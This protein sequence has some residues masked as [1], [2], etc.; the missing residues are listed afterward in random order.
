MTKTGKLNEL[1]ESWNKV[2]FDVFCKDG[3]ID[4]ETY[5]K[6]KI[7]ILFV[8]KDVNNAKP[9]EKVDLR[10]SL[11]TRTDEGKT[12]FNIARWYAGLNG[13]E[14]SEEITNMTSEKQHAAMRKVAVMNIKKEAGGPEV[15]DECILTYAKN[16]VEQI[17]REIEICNP[18]IV[19]ACGRVVFKSLK[20]EVFKINSDED[21]S[22][23]KVA[24]DGKMINYGTCFD[25]GRFLNMDKTVYV[26]E[27]RHPNQATLQGTFAEHH[28]NMLKIIEFL[29]N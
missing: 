27:Y 24:F 5:D 8:L 11:V 21:E 17:K 3:I 13:A 9:D 4:E 29:F 2:G 18:D 14:Y 6:E 23:K 20:D 28:E 15:S 10:E 19:I 22:Y 12:W 26:V 1:F 7:K 25:I 16:S